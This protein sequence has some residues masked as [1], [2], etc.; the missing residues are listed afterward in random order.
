MLK[1]RE[2]VVLQSGRNGLKLKTVWT[3]NNTILYSK[4]WEHFQETN[5]L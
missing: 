1:I 5:I 2:K 3:Q 4:K